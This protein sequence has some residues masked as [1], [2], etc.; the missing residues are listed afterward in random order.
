[1]AQL[2]RSAIVLRS[3]YC[4]KGR[5]TSAPR[6]GRNRFRNFEEGRQLSIATTAYARSSISGIVKF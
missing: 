5:G 2:K 1:M 6:I 3:G 4:F